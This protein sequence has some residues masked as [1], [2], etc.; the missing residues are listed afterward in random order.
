MNRTFFVLAK[1]RY[2]SQYLISEIGG[3]IYIK[4]KYNSMKFT[5]RSVKEYEV[6]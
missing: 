2:I 1:N 6:I 3:D 5:D 4:V